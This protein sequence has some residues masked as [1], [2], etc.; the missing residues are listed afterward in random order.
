M[1]VFAYGVLQEHEF[2]LELHLLKPSHRCFAGKAGLNVNVSPGALASANPYLYLPLPLPLRVGGGVLVGGNVG[3]GGE[4]GVEGGGVVGGN[5]GGEEGVE[6]GRVVGGN[7]GGEERV[8]GGN[9]G[10]EEGEEGG[11]VVGGNVGGEGVEGPSLS[12]YAR[13]F[14]DPVP[15]LEMALGVAR[16]VTAALTWF[17]SRDAESEISSAAIPATCGAAIE[18]P[19][20]VIVA[21]SLVDHAAVIDD[22]GANIFVQVPKLEKLERESPC[23]TELTE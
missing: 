22:P 11:G 16:L 20:M 21:V 9:V 8:V 3:V 19:E 7:V 2:S 18:V 10:G 6:G 12:L 17:T 23:C 15:G 1:W 5:V 14:G 13:R 4:E